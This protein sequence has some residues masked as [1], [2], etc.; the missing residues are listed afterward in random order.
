MDKTANQR[1][2]FLKHLF[3]ALHRRCD[4]NVND[5]GGDAGKA[6]ISKRNVARQ[7]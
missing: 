1:S 6:Q 2:P 4:I 5:N 7:L 3:G